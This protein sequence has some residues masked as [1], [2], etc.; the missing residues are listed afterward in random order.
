MAEYS[1]ENRAEPEKPLEKYMS[2]SDC[3]HVSKCDIEDP[4]MSLTTGAHV[5]PKP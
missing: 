4:M 5:D 1:Q 3:A 2:V